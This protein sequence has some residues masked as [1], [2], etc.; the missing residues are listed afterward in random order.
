MSLTDFK[1]EINQCKY[2]PSR[3]EFFFLVGIENNSYLCRSNYKK[4]IMTEIFRFFGF[5]FFFY[6]REHD[7]LHVHVEGN[8]G[9]AKF[10]W[11]GTEFVV[12]ERMGIKAGDFKKI[13]AV[14]DE[15]A[16]IIIA[17]WNKHFNQ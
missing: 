3:P 4:D 16:D 2:S 8:G 17:Q 5:S 11:N 1:V 10:E 15:N 6:S 12:V 9:M 14:I 13:K 7:P